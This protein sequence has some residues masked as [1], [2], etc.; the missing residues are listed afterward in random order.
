MIK[1]ANITRVKC[2]A[3]G[4]RLFDKGD[5][6]CGPVQM[7][8]GRCKQ[9]WEVELATDKFKQVSGKTKARRKGDSASP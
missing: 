1:E 2:P 9:V 4:Y 5:Q 7:K 6:A 8:C 3:C